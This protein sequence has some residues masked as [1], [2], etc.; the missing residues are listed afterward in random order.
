[1]NAINGMQIYCPKNRA[2]RIKALTGA[3]AGRLLLQTR[4]LP[5]QHKNKYLHKREISQTYFS[6]SFPPPVSH[7][8][9]PGAFPEGCPLLSS[10]VVNF[11]ALLRSQ[12]EKVEKKK[13]EERER[14]GVEK[15]E[16]SSNWQ[17]YG[18]GEAQA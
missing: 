16:K 4:L 12:G 2:L 1:M 10:S 7:T 3:Q 18:L 6:F 9:L 5:L 13:D 14:G 17:Q 8:E 11:S 15:R